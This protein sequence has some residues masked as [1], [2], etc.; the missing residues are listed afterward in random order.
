MI[1]RLKA[2]SN[3]AEVETANEKNQW[4]QYLNGEFEAPLAFK[5]TEKRTVKASSRQQTAI[6]S[7]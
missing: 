4:L 6:R 1:P 5:P 3:K 2:K 7:K